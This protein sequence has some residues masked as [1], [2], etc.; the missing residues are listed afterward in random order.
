MQKINLLSKFHTEKIQE[1]TLQNSNNFKTGS[2]LKRCLPPGGRGL[3]S[4][5]H[6]PRRHAFRLIWRGECF[7]VI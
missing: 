7:L 6:T 4:S 2:I 1:L 3:I 5:I